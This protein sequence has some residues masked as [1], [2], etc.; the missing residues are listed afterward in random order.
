[1]LKQ[2]FHKKSFKH[3]NWKNELMNLTQLKMIILINNVRHQAFLK[4][5]ITMVIFKKRDFF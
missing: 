4:W 3:S 1:M 2:I 5:S